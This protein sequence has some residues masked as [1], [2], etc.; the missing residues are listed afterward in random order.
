MAGREGRTASALAPKSSTAV[1]IALRHLLHAAEWSPAR[2]PPRMS[3]SHSARSKSEESRSSARR[4]RRA[5]V[6]HVQQASAAPRATAL[7][8]G[9]WT[10]AFR[11]PA[12]RS[13][14]ALFAVGGG[15]VTAGARAATTCARMPPRLA[16]RWP[17]SRSRRI[18]RR[19]QVLRV[20]RGETKRTSGWASASRISRR[21][22][23]EARRRRRHHGTE[24]RRPLRL[25]IRCAVRGAVR[26]ART[27][28]V[29][30]RRDRPSSRTSARSRRAPSS[31]R[32]SAIEVASRERS[33]PPRS[34]HA[35]TVHVVAA[36]HSRTT[37]RDASTR[38]HR[39]DLGVSL[40]GCSGGGG[41]VA[42]IGIHVGAARA[43]RHRARRIRSA[44]QARCGAAASARAARRR[45]L[46]R[47]QA[48]A[49]I[50]PARGRRVAQ[51]ARRLCSRGS[52]TTW[53]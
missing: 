1:T 38:A 14:A 30:S 3:P 39:R 23:T 45:R 47:A 26:P 15:R 28:G 34:S 17:R 4:V 51:D 46:D 24:A 13:S 12:R 20:R 33:R 11:A 40:L 48:G 8:A 41:L 9:G 22:R 44:Q 25:R 43:P 2:A 19:R 10:G 29:R 35:A 16:R 32:R 36:A 6:A 18:W 37:S 7:G 52:R 42:Q 53:R 50:P 5:V 21:H 27:V 31:R 49:A